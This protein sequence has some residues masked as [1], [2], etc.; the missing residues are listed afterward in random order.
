ML[1]NSKT[2]CIYNFE[3]MCYAV[4]FLFLGSIAFTQET[5]VVS[6]LDYNDWRTLKQIKISNNGNLVSYET[7]PHRGDGILTLH[8]LE[9]EDTIKV[10][11]ANNVTFSHDDRFAVFK[12]HPGYDTLRNLE[13]EKVKKEKWVK[14]SLGVLNVQTQNMVKWPAIKKMQL[15]EHTNLLVALSYEKDKTENSKK[16]KKSNNGFF[17]W[18]KRE[19][20]NDNIE[21]L[22][23]SLYWCFL[24][25]SWNGNKE[26]IP[27]VADF[28][29]SDKQNL[30][31]YSTKYKENKKDYYQLHLKNTNN[32]EGVDLSQKFTAVGHWG[33]DENGGKLFFLASQDTVK[34]NKQFDLY[35]WNLSDSL[36]EV[37]AL[38]LNDDDEVCWPSEHRKPYFS[39][40]GKRLFF[41]VID[42]IEQ[43]PK[44]TLLKSEKPVLDVWHYL[45]DRLQP[46]QLKELDRNQKKSLLSV[47]HL[48]DNSVIILDN[49]D[50][51]FYPD[52]NGEAKLFL[53]RDVSPYQRNYNWSYPWLA[54]YHVVDVRT[55]ERKK[56]KDSVA[57]SFGLS[58]KGNYFVYFNHKDSHWHFIDTRTLQD[59]CISCFLQDDQRV[60]WTRDVNGMPH[61]PGTFGIAGFTKDEESLVFYSELDIWEVVLLNNSLSCITRAHGVNNNVELRLINLEKDSVYITLNNALIQSVDKNTG[62]HALM[63]LKKGAQRYDL[64]TLYTTNHAIS[65][66]VKAKNKQQLIFR[67]GNVKDYP[68]LFLT[69][70]DFQEVQQLSNT[71]PQQSE[72]RWP[73]VEKISWTTP[74]GIETDG[75][76][77][78][79]EDFDST[80]SYPMLVYFYEMYTD[81]IHQ[82]YIPR[83]TASIIFPTEYTSAEYI[84]FIPDVRYETGHP[85]KSAFDCI[86]SGTD[87]VLRRY[88]NI[89]TMRLGLQGQSWGGYQTA[90]LITMTDK[91]KAA[92]AG[93][94]VSNMF[95]A[96]GGIRWGSGLNR[97]FQYEKTQS[98]IGATIW[99]APELYVENSPLFG[100][101][102][103]QTPLLMMHNDDDGA[104]PWYQGIELYTAMKRLGKPVWLLNYNGDK[105]NLMKNANRMD[106]SIRMRQFFDHYLKGEPA[107]KWL[108]EGLPAIEK[109]KSN[110]LELVE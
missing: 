46:Q 105:H 14:D 33:F 3:Q 81:R 40:D 108:S 69:E 43:E 30:F 78:K 1:K 8:D 94:P 49:D 70:L 4:C 100:V 61:A 65:N 85:A 23:K 51:S 9:K 45:D 29:L 109:G 15:S 52:K 76:V 73:T 107:P 54:D 7:T 59:E 36:P 57:Y 98:R 26:A 22:G 35:I 77:Y 83:P 32:S 47:M 88:P 42:P 84:V 110:G 24:D 91:Y 90:Q 80:K 28:L 31:I 75:L 104:V 39:K 13:L 53:G 2:S 18:F 17:G 50:V 96:Y 10:D 34:N 92:M 37:V 27:N 25:E 62:D 93:A 66:I 102:N 41:G 101:P 6:H 86:V 72:Y 55:G 106:L 63:R 64:E 74:E 44:E 103:I 58:T 16:N 68:E 97:Q 67:K 5:K 60:Q 89:D 82:H 19:T 20:T 38:P 48:D 56:V 79:P 87:E 12:I 21:K 99:E 71:N 95:S 11:R